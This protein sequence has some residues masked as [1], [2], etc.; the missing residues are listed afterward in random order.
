MAETIAGIGTERARSDA[1]SLH[2]IMEHI[3]NLLTCGYVRRQRAVQYDEFTQALSTALNSTCSLDEAF[4]IPQKLIVDYAGYTVTFML[5]GENHNETGLATLQVSKKGKSIE[6]SVEKNTYCRICTVLLI[7]QRFG[8]SH[9]SITLTERGLMDMRGANLSRADLSGADMR[10]ADLSGAD[11]SESNLSKADLSGADLGNAILW[12]TDLTE[13]LLAGANLSNAN[14]SGAKLYGADLSNLSRQGPLLYLPLWNAINIKFFLDH[15][16]NGRDSSL[17][18]MMDSIDERYA[19][20][21][22]QM[23]RELIDSLQGA[24]VSSVAPL[25]MDVL[26]KTPYNGDAGMTAWL[27]TVC[28]RYLNQYDAEALPQLS[29]DRLKQ[30]ADLFLCQPERMFSHNSAFI[31]LV[32]QGMKTGDGAIKASM[33]RLYDGYLNHEKVRPYVV[34]DDFGIYGAQRPD[35][36]DENAANYILFPS[37]PEGPVMLLSAHTLR[38][39][40]EPDPL[41]PVWDR[42]FLYNQQ[43]ENLQPSDHPLETLFGDDFRLFWA[44]Y[45]FAEKF[46]SFAKLLET[47]QLGNRRTLFLSATRVKTS[48]VKLVDQASHEELRKIFSPT[49]AYSTDS[50]DYSL[51]RAHYDEILVTYDLSRAS[52]NH[53]AKTLLTLAA[54]FNKYSSK[55]I[56]GTE[57]ESPEML[58][59]YAYALMEKAYALD[60]GVFKGEKENEF[61]NWR[62]RLLGLDGAF[63]CSSDLS[64]RMLAYIRENFPDVL[65]DI[66][67]PAW[68]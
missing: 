24:K 6:S 42:F 34:L 19:D 55:A 65:A 39:M 22:L 11:M 32:A 36:T 33:T 8:L 4:R 44:S 66:M 10:E 50:G 17:L 14:L 27:D 57:S 16:A 7:R 28:H 2:G 46:A 62:N 64:I 53:K 9:S 40:L 26:S 63:S 31:Q 30:V 58:R 67:P 38:S 47:L 21:K 61:A 48:G 12:N 5:P 13:T 56:F 20:V 43:G 15:K 68:S 25:L 59:R 35:W 37:R 3:V 52:D 45:R 41:T 51:T 23:A 60:A 54:V 1:N 29:E 49:L 18:T